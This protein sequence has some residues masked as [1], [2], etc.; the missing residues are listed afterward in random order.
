V[1]ETTDPDP[2]LDPAAQEAAGARETIRSAY[3]IAALFVERLPARAAFDAATA[4]AELLRDLAERA[5][6]LRARMAAR[7]AHDEGLSVRA[8]ARELGLAKS[9]AGDLLARAERENGPT[10]G[11]GG[12]VDRAD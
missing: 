12:A 9:K 6:G 8:L 1:A 2:R 11:E 4:L 5:A 10:P 3:R 7:I